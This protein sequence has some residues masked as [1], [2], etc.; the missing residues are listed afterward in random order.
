MEQ[1]SD[2]C[3]SYSIGCECL[4]STLLIISQH[5]T[6]NIVVAK[7][8]KKKKKKGKKNRHASLEK[9]PHLHANNSS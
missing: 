9:M 6:N 5:D 3:D 2:F 8:D 7:K 4:G 1:L